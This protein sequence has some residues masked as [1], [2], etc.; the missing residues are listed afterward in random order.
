MKGSD[1]TVGKVRYD[2][3]TILAT[4][5]DSVKKACLVVQ[6][7]A[8]GKDWYYKK[9]VAGSTVVSLADINSEIDNAHF[10]NNI[11]LTSLDNCKI[12]LETTDDTRAT[13][14]NAAV[15]RKSCI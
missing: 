12:W 3:D 6:G 9:G 7:K 4:K 11:N 14:A 2:S 10:D 13:Y 1:A 8:E 5:S 15:Y